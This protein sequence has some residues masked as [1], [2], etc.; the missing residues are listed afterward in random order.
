MNTDKT[1]TTK[2][3]DRKDYPIWYYK[4]LRETTVDYVIFHLLKESF[5]VEIAG[6]KHEITFGK[7]RKAEIGSSIRYDEVVQS[8]LTSYSVID[9]GFREGTWYTITDIDTTDEFKAKYVKDK[10]AYEREKTEQWYRKILTNVVTKAKEL[11]EAQKNKYLQEIANY[12]YEELDTLVNKLFE[13]A[14]K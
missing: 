2:F 8:H 5:V 13:K 6:S 7:N 4:E 3:I 9:K 1:V 12:T 14:H 11:S 10:E